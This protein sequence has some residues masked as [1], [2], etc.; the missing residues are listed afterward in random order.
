MHY[1]AYSFDKEQHIRSAADLEARDDEDAVN[2]ARARF[3]ADLNCHMI[4]V[5]QA[6][7]RLH[8]EVVAH[9]VSDA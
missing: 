5:W 2:Q 7:R 6:K 3:A 9:P 4:Q 8:H 1:R